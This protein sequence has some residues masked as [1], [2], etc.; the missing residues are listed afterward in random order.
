MGG[1]AI[2]KNDVELF[3]KHFSDSC[4]FVTRLG[5]S[6]TETL[7][8]YFMRKHTE[9]IGEHVPVGYPLEGNE[10]LIVDEAGNDVGANQVGEIAVRSRYLSVG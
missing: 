6:E 3:K 1:E 7:T 5:L 9:I 10:I 4:L 2:S 8:Y